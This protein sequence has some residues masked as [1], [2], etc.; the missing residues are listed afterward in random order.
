MIRDGQT[1]FKVRVNK[2]G[3]V[4]MVT[5]VVGCLTGHELLSEWIEHGGEKGF[6]R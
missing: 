1:Y 4:M 6:Q 5:W 2:G 3:F